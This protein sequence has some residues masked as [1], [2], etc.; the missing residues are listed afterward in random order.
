MAD[1]TVGDAAMIRLQAQLLADAGSDAARDALASLAVEAQ[2]VGDRALAAQAEALA[3]D[4]SPRATV[5]RGF[6]LWP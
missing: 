2:K 4:A 6:V 5:A 1:A 3:K